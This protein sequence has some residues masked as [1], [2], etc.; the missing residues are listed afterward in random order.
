M[1]LGFVNLLAYGSTSGHQQKYIVMEFLGQTIKDFIQI[2]RRPF[3]LKTVIQIGIQ[4]VM[5]L[6]P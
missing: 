3:S 4:L 6:F 5:P 2:K 1:N